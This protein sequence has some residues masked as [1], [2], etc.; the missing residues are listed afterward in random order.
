MKLRYSIDM[1]HEPSVRVGVCNR[2]SKQATLVRLE[3]SLLQQGG[4][5]L[6]AMSVC[7][8]CIQ[9]FVDEVEG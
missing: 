2:C 8:S 3:T 7:M 6:G 5:P 4:I 9:E 1:I